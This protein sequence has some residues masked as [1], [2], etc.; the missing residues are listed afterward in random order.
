MASMRTCCAR[1]IEQGSQRLPSADSVE[2]TVDMSRD[3]AKA[4]FVAV[5]LDAT[6][7]PT[8]S[9]VRIERKQLVTPS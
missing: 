6:P 2:T 3:R 4:A 7:S 9:D 5:Q 8:A 1:W